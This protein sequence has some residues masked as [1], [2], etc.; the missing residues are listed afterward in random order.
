[1]TENILSDLTTVISLTSSWLSKFLANMRMVNVDKSGRFPSFWKS[2]SFIPTNF[3]HKI[4]SNKTLLAKLFPTCVSQLI[5]H[6]IA[7]SNPKNHLPNKTKTYMCIFHYKSSINA[8]FSYCVL[9]IYFLNRCWD[10][11]SIPKQIIN[12]HPE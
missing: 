6:L 1:M 9:P 2:N 5:T 3:I 12:P 11:F 7:L 8:L 4:T 10:P